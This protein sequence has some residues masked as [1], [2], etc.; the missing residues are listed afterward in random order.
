M[1][2]LFKGLADIAGRATGA[3]R[4]LTKIAAGQDPKGVFNLTNFLTQFFSGGGGMGAARSEGAS[5]GASASYMDNLNR[6]ANSSSS[7]AAPQPQNNK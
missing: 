6:M 1:I 2:P 4:G 3:V 7:R 5:D